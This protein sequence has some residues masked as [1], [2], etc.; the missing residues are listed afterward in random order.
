[1]YAAWPTEGRAGVSG[2]HRHP[3]AHKDSLLIL[4]LTI[5]LAIIEY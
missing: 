3:L 1:M 5:Y 2:Q 4:N